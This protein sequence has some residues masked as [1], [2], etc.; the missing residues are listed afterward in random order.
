M[1]FRSEPGTDPLV[2]LIYTSG[3]TGAPKANPKRWRDFADGVQQNLAALAGLYNE[4]APSIVATVPPQHMY[5][6]EMS[7][8]PWPPTSRPS[9]RNS[10]AV[11]SRTRS[12]R[13][14]VSWRN[15]ASASSS[16]ASASSG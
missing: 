7:V 12:S 2:T 5:G 13:V 6:V 1:L 15:C 16:S 10:S 4:D 3:S 11:R 9:A 14:S 8:L